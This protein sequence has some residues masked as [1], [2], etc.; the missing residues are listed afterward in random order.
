MYQYGPNG[1]MGTASFSARYRTKEWTAT[2]T[3]SPRGVMQASYFHQFSNKVR[4]EVHLLC[5]FFCL[6]VYP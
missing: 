1:E 5:L 2:G 4:S 3:V 6:M